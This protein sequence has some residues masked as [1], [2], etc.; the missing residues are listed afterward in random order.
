MW[1]KVAFSLL[2][3]PGFGIAA[4]MAIISKHIGAVQVYA[5]GTNISGLPVYAGQDGMAYIS[6]S[7][8]NLTTID[9]KHILEGISSILTSLTLLVNIDS[10]GKLPWN[11]TGNFSTT[12]DREFYIVT[13]SG[14]YEQAG[15]VEANSSLPSG[16][17]KTGF[18]TYGAY[19]VYLDTNK[20]LSEFW[21]QAINTAGTWA[22]KWNE[23]GSSQ[24]NS[25]PVSLKT[26]APTRP[27]HS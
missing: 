9:C 5:Y 26:M 11:V 8:E 13:T 4:D 22:L 10:T 1:F 18:M 17:V 25:V 16:A 2:A 3:L 24:T 12:I 7:S 19:I 21:A 15:F 6:E 20:I 27:N 23:D 14:A